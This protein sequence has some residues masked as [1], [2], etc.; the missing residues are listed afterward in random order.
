M[1]KGEKM[2]FNKEAKVFFDIARNE[3]FTVTEEQYRKAE[4]RYEEQLRFNSELAKSL[5][6]ASGAYVPS[7]YIETETGPHFN[8]VYNEAEDYSAYERK[9]ENMD[10]DMAL[11]IV[12]AVETIK[13]GIAE[14]LEKGNI[15]VYKVANIIRIDVK[16]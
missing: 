12:K 5:D 15:K 6:H 1:G 3:C 11:W 16:E 9:E 14:K 4:E 10:A 13:S 8:W 2:T 7:F